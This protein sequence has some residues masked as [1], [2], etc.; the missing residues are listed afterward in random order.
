M[1]EPALYANSGGPCSRTRTEAVRSSLLGDDEGPIR[2][3]RVIRLAIDFGSDDPRET[4]YT[5]LH[6]QG[7]EHPEELRAVVD[8]LPEPMLCRVNASMKALN[9]RSANPEML[10]RAALLLGLSTAVFYD[11]ARPVIWTKASLTRRLE[12]FETAGFYA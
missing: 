7:L 6:A 3:P 12:L 5:L 4:M 9:A 2:C 10:L 11:P 1:I 8:V